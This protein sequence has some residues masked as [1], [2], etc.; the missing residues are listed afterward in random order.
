M[1]GDGGALARRAA[2]PA[3]ALTASITS[4]SQGSP[5][6]PSAL[7]P[8]LGMTTMGRYSQPA[9]LPPLHA[10]APAAAASGT[11]T[12]P[13]SPAT[14]AAPALASATSA[15]RTPAR[16][17][18]GRAAG[19]RLRSKCGCG[20]RPGRSG[21]RDMDAMQARKDAGVDG[22]TNWRPSGALVERTA[23]ERKGCRR[24]GV[25]S[26]TCRSRSSPAVPIAR[27]WVALDE[28]SMS[29]SAETALTAASLRRET[30]GTSAKR[31]CSMSCSA[32][33]RAALTNAGSVSPS[34]RSRR[35]RKTKSCTEPAGLRPQSKAPRNNNRDAVV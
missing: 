10:S 32:S 33:S 22:S 23:L 14:A 4:Q 26:S 11:R 24:S 9:T 1:P 16:K 18:R 17:R 3:L 19:Q 31:A 2:Q 15:R 13:R 34:T 7:P 21:A 8:P 27:P 28:R 12:P 20:P 30:R 35:N 25:E 5:P 29:R 6:R